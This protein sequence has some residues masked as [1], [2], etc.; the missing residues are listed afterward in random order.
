MRS[1]RHAVRIS[2]PREAHPCTLRRF[3][4]HRKWM[5]GIH[6]ACN[7]VHLAL[8]Y[9]LQLAAE[10]KLFPQECHAFIAPRL[11]SCV[12]QHFSF[13]R[14]SA[15]L[16][17]GFFL[18]TCCFVLLTCCY[19]FLAYRLICCAICVGLLLT[20]YLECMCKCD[21]HIGSKRFE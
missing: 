13:A 21:D 11:C 19:V 16:M 14:C 2:C 7:K 9:W 20:Q 12:L 6:F 18:L 3:R 17:L 8:C 5:F 15:C 1:H 10:T 4:L